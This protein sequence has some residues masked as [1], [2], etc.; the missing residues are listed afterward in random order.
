LSSLLKSEKRLNNYLIMLDMVVLWQIL[1]GEHDHMHSHHCYK[2]KRS[3]DPQ[4]T[5]LDASYQLSL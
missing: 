5:M 2:N 4:C 3:P 1:W